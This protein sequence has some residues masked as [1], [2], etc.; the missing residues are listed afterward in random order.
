MDELEQWLADAYASAYR[1]AYLITRNAADAEEAVQEAF[2]RVWP[3]PRRHPKARGGAHGSTAWSR[4]PACPGCA[5]MLA[6]GSV[7]VRKRCRTCPQVTIR[8]TA[9]CARSLRAPSRPRS[10]TCPRGFRVPI[11][12]RYYAGLSE[13]EIALA[14]HRRPGTVKSR[15]H[16]GRA[17]CRPTPAQ[18]LG[19]CPRRCR[20]DH[21]RA[22]GTHAARRR[23]C[24]DVPEH[25][26]DAVR[27]ALREVPYDTR[28]DA[29]SC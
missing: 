14:I 29:R 8:P 27:A 24:I 25:G 22:A 5:L 15:L 26:P 21:R 7:L 11:V 6:G 13:K 28:R 9:L 20:H 18:Q 2:L 23:R 12:L 10:P 1:T 3:V 19:R 17:R 4:T 16:D